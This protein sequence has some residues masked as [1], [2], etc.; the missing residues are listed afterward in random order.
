MVAWV[1]KEAKKL[2]S[3]NQLYLERQPHDH[4]SHHRPEVG[5]H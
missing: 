3:S 1:G 5:E 4:G 2:P